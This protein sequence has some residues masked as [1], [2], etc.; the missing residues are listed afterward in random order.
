M[1]ERPEASPPQQ[2]GHAAVYAVLRDAG[3]DAATNALVWRA[4]AAYFEALA[5]E[6]AAP[7]P[8]PEGGQ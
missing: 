8:D 4:L 7:H 3:R 6:L 2:R 1:P 5:A